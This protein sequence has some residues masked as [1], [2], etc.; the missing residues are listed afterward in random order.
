MNI[1]EK[2]LDTAKSLYI[3]LTTPGK[4]VESNSFD[5]CMHNYNVEILNFSHPELQLL[6]TKPMI[7]KN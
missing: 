4:Y 7:K 5:N 3:F 6:N 2:S 1:D